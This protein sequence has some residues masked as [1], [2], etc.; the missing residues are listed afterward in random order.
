MGNFSEP[1]SLAASRPESDR[2]LRDGVVRVIGITLLGVAI[3]HLT[4][5]LGGLGWDSPWLWAGQLWFLLLSFVVWQG[6]RLLILQL[7][8]RLDWVTRPVR[9]LVILIVG[10]LAY[11]LTL[12]V[13]AMVVWFATAPYEK[14]D[15]SRTMLVAAVV[16]I[17][18]LFVTHVY[19]T[20]FL[21]SGRLEDRLRLEQSERRRLQTELDLIKGQLAPHFLF[22]CLH[23]LGVLIAENP[24]KARSFNQHLAVV[25]R[26]LLVQQE[27]DL[28]PLAEEIAFFEA[29]AELSRLRYPEG[30]EIKMEGFEVTAGRYIPPA[31]LQLLLENALKHNG[32]SATEPLQIRVQLQ[33]SNIRFTNSCPPLMSPPAPGT[34]LGLKN[35]RER[36]LHVVR[37]EIKVRRDPDRFE[38]N[39]PLLPD[40]QLPASRIWT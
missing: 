15:W 26:Y 22:N 20:T 10:T 17:A 36:Y 30:L 13:V 37:Q 1:R 40:E 33:D 6:N 19:E 27:R 31:S 2:E 11:S 5:T 18:V 29:Y 9:K 25:C 28:V 14:I 12:T 39:L 21:I 35:L 4:G 23:V 16:G 34:G 8:R 38:V 24:A 32:C 7:R 3:P